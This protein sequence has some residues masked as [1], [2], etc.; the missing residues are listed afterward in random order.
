MGAVR[1]V[2]PC[3]NTAY[4]PIAK[5]LHWVM[6]LLLLSLVVLGATMTELPLSPLKLQLYSWH[7]WAGVSVFLLVLIRL[8]WRWKNPPAPLPNH[9]P[10]AHR[11]AA[12]A[13]HMVLYSLMALI[14]LS[15]WLMSSAKGVQTVWFGV[16]P[17]PDLLDKN[18]EL[19]DALVTLHGGLNLLLLT[20][21]AAHVGAALWHHFIRKDD[22][23][24]RMI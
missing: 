21:V 20:L 3:M 18:K 15:G 2:S 22:L 24:Q 12:H 9:I 13:T 1:T 11:T 7:K 17:L 23:L 6:A 4:H 8:M 16:L 5:S 19:A 10:K 14:P